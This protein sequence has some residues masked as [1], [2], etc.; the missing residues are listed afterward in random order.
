MRFVIHVAALLLMGCGSQT[1]CGPEQCASVCAQ[2]NNPD[3]LA[4]SNF[5]RTLFEPMVKDTREGIRAWDDKSVG[6]CRGAGRDCEEFLGIDAQNL[7]EGEYMMRAELRVPHVGERGTWKVRFETE[8][9]TTRKTANGDS[10]TTNT[11][12]RDFD[13]QWVGEDR[14]ARLSPLY[15]IRSPNPNGAQSCKWKLTGL[16]PPGTN[17]G[18]SGIWSVP[19]GE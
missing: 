17:N 6:V 3:A 2:Q 14:G 16:N 7:P 19:A 8:C 18:W 5:E 4:L 12:T 9:T 11:S 15:K 10:N 1:T 13:I